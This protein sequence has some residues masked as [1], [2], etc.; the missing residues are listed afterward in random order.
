VEA[1]KQEEARQALIREKEARAS[2]LAAEAAK[3]A[4]AQTLVDARE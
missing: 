2:S 4:A 1:A 3:L